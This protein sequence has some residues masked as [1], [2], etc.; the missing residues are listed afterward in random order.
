VTPSGRSLT[1]GAVQPTWQDRDVE[2]D[3]RWPVQAGSAQGGPH[4]LRSVD[5]VVFVVF[6]VLIHASARSKTLAKLG[7]DWQDIVRKSMA[8]E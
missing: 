8:D 1:S 7:Q 6:W 3:G 4:H 2:S 5:M